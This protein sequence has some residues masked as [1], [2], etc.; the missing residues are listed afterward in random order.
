MGKTGT[1]E[2]NHGTQKNNSFCLFIGTL[3]KCL[4][5]L[6]IIYTILVLCIHFNRKDD[7]VSTYDTI[8]KFNIP[9]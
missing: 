6:L 7:A 4:A 9:P 3:L 1:Y 8:D 2:I 5:V